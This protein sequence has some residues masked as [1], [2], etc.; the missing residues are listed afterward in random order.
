MFTLI[1]FTLIISG[2]VAMSQLLKLSVPWVSYPTE[3]LSGMLESILILH[4]PLFFPVF[5]N[6][7]VCSSC[8]VFCLLDLDFSLCCWGD[9]I[10]GFFFTQYMT[11][12]N[13]TSINAIGLNIPPKRTTVLEFL[14]K[15]NEDFAMIQESHLLYKDARRFA[16]KLYHP[17]A[18]LSA[19]TKSMVCW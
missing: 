19:V 5:F 18:P 15:K 16:N 7:M 3:D 8:G 1:L 17:V 6:F 2:A 9:C 4:F 11:A 10:F 14:L 12:L 13:L